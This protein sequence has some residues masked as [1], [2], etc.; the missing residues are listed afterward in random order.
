MEYFKGAAPYLSSPF[1]DANFTYN[2]V[3]T[4][5][6][7]QTPRW[8]RMSQLLLMAASENYWVSCM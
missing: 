3:I 2:Q 5:Q 4:G 7:V 8:Q 6:K 1:V